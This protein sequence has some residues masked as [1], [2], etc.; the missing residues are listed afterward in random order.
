MYIM[1]FVIVSHQRSVFM[2]FSSRAGILI[3]LL[4]FTGYSFASPI[5][6]CPSVNTIKNLG[7][8]KAKI[9]IYYEVYNTSSYD[10]DHIWTFG[11]GPVQAESVEEA[12]KIGNDWLLTLSGNPTPTYTGAHAANCLYEIGHNGYASATTNEDAYL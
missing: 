12:I 6:K 10:T 5:T 4:M 2:F 7:L 8:T 11:L 3:A 1:K 9:F